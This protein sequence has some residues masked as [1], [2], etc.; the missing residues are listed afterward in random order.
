MLV[1]H[2][3]KQR[4]AL[5]VPVPCSVILAK[6]KVASALKWATLR[7]L[8]PSPW[9]YPFGVRPL[10]ESASLCARGGTL[11]VKVRDVL[12]V[13]RAHEPGKILSALRDRWADAGCCAA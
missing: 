7:L 2:P 8:A 12:R 3:P 4:R 9:G 5:E 11:C 13:A 10:W 6:K 1:A